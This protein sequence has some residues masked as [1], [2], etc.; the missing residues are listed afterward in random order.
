MTTGLKATAL[1][2]A[3]RVVL[4]GNADVAI[5]YSA[6]V[7]GSEVVV[8]FNECPNFGG[9][10]GT[11]TTILCLINTGAVGRDL[12]KQ[13]R[14]RELAP[15]RQ[16]GEIWFRGRRDNWLDALLITLFQFRR[17]KKKLDYGPKLMRANG[18][19]DTPAVYPP[20]G[21]LK[22]ARRKL[23]AVDPQRPWAKVNPSSGFLAIERVLDDPRFAGHEVCLIGFTWER[24]TPRRTFRDQHTWD[25]EETLCREHDTKG[26]L[27]IL[28]CA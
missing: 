23:R 21:F 7:D 5:D 26:V 22:R 20:R 3:Q 13:A 10:T 27:K 14:L 25:E 19:R 17:R 28:P 12:Y 11:R 4:I 9:N 8:R 15:A 2:L 16:A 6:L 1:Q 18:L 24:G